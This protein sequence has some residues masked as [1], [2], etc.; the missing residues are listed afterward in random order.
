MPR[1]T[2]LTL[3]GRSIAHTAT[4]FGTHFCWDLSHNWRWRVLPER[5]RGVF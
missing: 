3:C 1:D 4:W 5:E 2:S